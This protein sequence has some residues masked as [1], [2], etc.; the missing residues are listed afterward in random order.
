M[1]IVVC[2]HEKVQ[3]KRVSL[4]S[5]LSLGLI[6]F[7]SLRFGVVQPSCCSSTVSLQHY[8]SSSLHN[9]STA[10]YCVFEDRE[11]SLFSLVFLCWA[12]ITINNLE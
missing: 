7:F 4:L 9:H 5:G 6:V 3:Q 11:S 1:H 10:V 12:A 8:S 2:A